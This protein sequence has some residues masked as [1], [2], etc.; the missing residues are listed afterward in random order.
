[1]RTILFVDGTNLYASQLELVGA[2]AHLLFP[3]FIQQVEKHLKTTFDH[4]YV[5]AS[6]SPQ[7]KVWSAKAKAYLK[8]EALFYKSMKRLPNLTFFKGYRSP[9]SGKEKE[10]DVK[11]AV[12]IVDFA[13]RDLYDKAVVMSG[14]A[15]FMPA[16]KIIEGLGK[17]IQVLC[18]ENRIP[19]RV[20]QYYPTLIAVYKKRKLPKGLTFSSFILLSSVFRSV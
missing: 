14:D 3:E 10:V 13:H 7:P 16:L 19:R 5:Y 20:A 12:D 2:G 18:L 17:E 15:D 9:T 6:Y 11:M 1:V 8:N 4:L